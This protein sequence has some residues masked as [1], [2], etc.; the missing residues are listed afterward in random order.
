MTVAWT[1]SVG[2]AALV[3]VATVLAVAGCGEA[4]PSG[5]EVTLR[6]TRDFGNELIDAER[7]PLD[8]HRTVL[9]LLEEN[10]E[11]DASEYGGI[12]AIDGLR[13]RNARFDGDQDQT[14]AINVNGI[15]NDYGVDELRLFPGDVVQLDLRDW[16]VTLDVRATV[17][18]FPQPFTGGMLGRRFPVT[19]RCAPGFGT[20]C[21]EVRRALRAAGVDPS[22][23][24]P[25]G[26]PPARALGQLRRASI[27]VGPWRHW[28]DRAWPRRID[29]GPRYSGVFAR[30]S[31][32]AKIVRLLDWDANQA[33]RLGVGTGLIAAMRPTSTDL[34][35]LVTGTDRQGVERAARA[36]DSRAIEDAFAAIV[37]GAGVRKI[38]LVAP[39]GG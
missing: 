12:E 14:W 26:K 21:G 10:H 20:A 38:P 16:Y 7:L 6:V 2:A 33:G 32:N 29:R 27:L 1:R 36:L 3:A 24:E 13:A 25:A 19:V 17:G 5:P 31:P 37:T 35:W 23:R 18:A 34:L 11:V 39:W 30:F 22:G 8:G 4:E 9:R 15:E 28:R